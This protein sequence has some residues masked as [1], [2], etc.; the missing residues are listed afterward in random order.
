MLRAEVPC[1]GCRLCC[2][3]MMVEMQPDRGDDASQYVTASWYRDGLDKPPVA[4][5]DRLPNGNCFYLGDG[6]C[7]IWDRTPYQCRMFDCREY[8][9]SHTRNQRRDLMK[10]DTAT[11]PLFERGRELLK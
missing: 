2:H 4:I 5:L 10:R 1:N 8:F 11:G 6:G 7:T 9:R 3:S